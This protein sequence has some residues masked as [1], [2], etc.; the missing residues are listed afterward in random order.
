MIYRLDFIPET[1]TKIYYD[2][3]QQSHIVPDNSDSS[4]TK[5]RS[6]MMFII[7]DVGYSHSV[8]GNH[9]SQD[10]SCIQAN[11]AACRIRA[12]CIRLWK[13]ELK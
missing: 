1:F 10:H 9:T 8:D 13:Q 7:Q 5:I 2:E 3:H 4:Q 12:L 11:V 6:F